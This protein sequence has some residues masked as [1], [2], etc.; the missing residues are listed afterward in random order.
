MPAARS[1]RRLATAASLPPNAA[2]VE[3][4]ARPLHAAIVAGA[5]G[6]TG[7][8]AS[9]STPAAAA[10]AADAFDSACTATFRWCA[11][12]AATATGI[13]AGCQP[14][15]VAGDLDQRD[16][17]AGEPVDRRRSRTPRRLQPMP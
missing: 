8:C 5:S 17:L 12:A 3:I 15:L 9:R 14:V 13:S 4:T 1:A 7:V 10:A 11:C 6:S 2:S 16:A